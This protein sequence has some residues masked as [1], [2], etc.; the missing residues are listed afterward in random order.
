[1]KAR[2]PAGFALV[3][4]L[5]L[6][7]LLVLAVFALSALTKVSSEI[8]IGSVY[9]TQARQ[10]AQLGLDSALGRLQQFAGPDS[11]LTGTADIVP[12]T[13]NVNSRWCGVWMVG[14]STAEWLVSG[15]A[16]PALYEPNFTFVAVGGTR[17]VV[18][19]SA[20]DVV[21]VGSGS[22][23]TAS[24]KYAPG[25]AV[26][27]PKV[28]ISVY[29]APGKSSSAG[30]YAYWVGD[31]GVKLSAA[32]PGL[33]APAS[34]APPLHSVSGFVIDGWTPDASAVLKALSYEQLVGAGA[35]PAAL[36]STFHGLTLLH[37]RF[38]DSGSTPAVRDGLINVNSAG[39]R[40]WQGVLSTSNSGLTIAN[41][42]KNNFAAAIGDKGTVWAPAGADK[43]ANGPFRTV[44]GFLDF[45][46]A[47][48]DAIVA[49]GA[50]LNNFK[51]ALRPWLTVRSDT[52]RIRA[53]GDAVNPVLDPGQ[54]AGKV[55]AV[56]CCEAIVQRV[57]DNPSAP[58]GH[59]VITYFRWLGPDDI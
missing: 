33:G 15:N 29:D 17:T 42:R 23:N 50:N 5:A 14:R 37:H 9:Q 16:N 59:F 3:I 25:D 2:H 53:Y 39:A 12:S 57:K 58:E 52:F 8:S 28:Q 20:A 36:R 43:M 27:V 10:N 35:G 49:S 21:L 40:L 13:R 11:S 22:T 19:A 4:T 56:A 54:T 32:L 26:I 45:N 51:N 38:L 41:A 55:E 46:P 47:V 7:A 1:M 48:T 34:P 30:N 6:L 18:P 24:S 31:E 44:A